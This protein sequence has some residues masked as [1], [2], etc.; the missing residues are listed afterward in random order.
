MQNI[1]RHGCR[2]QQ[3]LA[4]CR[5]VLDD[6]SDI[7]HKSHVEHPVCLVQDEH[8]Q[9]RQVDGALIE[10]VKQAAGTG[11]DNLGAAFQLIHLRIETDSSINS[12]ALE[13]GPASQ[14]ANGL[15]DLLGQFASGG[16]NQSPD[17][18]APALHQAMED[19]QHKGRGLPGAG[20]G[21]A[22][23]VVPL[24]DQRDCL[25]LYRRWRDITRRFN[26]GRDLG[27]KIKCVKFHK[28]LL[29]YVRVKIPGVFKGIG[30]GSPLEV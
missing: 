30:V 24:H 12:H 7:G 3:R 10:V 6:L 23:D 19:G 13:S 14:G 25:C 16:N 8:F 28:F 15:V 26:A 21:Q 18:P 29:F 20:L 1:I 9:M 2:E 4:F 11:N 5:Y 22:H 17:V 27:V